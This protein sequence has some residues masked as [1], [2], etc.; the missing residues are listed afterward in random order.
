MDTKRN[1]KSDLYSITDHIK[2]NTNILVWVGIFC[3]LGIVLGIIL[4][5]GEKSY[6]SLLTNQNQTLMGYI[7]GSVSTFGLLWNRLSTNLLALIIIFAFCLNY[8]TSYFCYLYFAYQCAVCT[9][10]CGT[11]IS[12]QGLSAIINIIFLII[13]SNIILLCILAFAFSVFASRAKRQYKFK[14]PF[15][16]SFSYDNFALYSTLSLSLI[17]VLNIIT[18]LIIPLIIKGIFQIYY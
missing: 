7:T 5:F 15:W 18:G 14:Q 1:I 13:P 6:L 4:L 2:Q 3:A 12:Y 9:L 16:N 17:I 11:L 8:F 10:I